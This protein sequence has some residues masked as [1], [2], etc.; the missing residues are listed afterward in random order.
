MTHLQFNVHPRGTGLYVLA[1]YTAYRGGLMLLCEGVIEE[2]E[3]RCAFLT[4]KG[5]PSAEPLM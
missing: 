5:R 4:R 2:G 1:T 3:Q